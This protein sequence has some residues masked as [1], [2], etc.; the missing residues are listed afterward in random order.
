MNILKVIRT[1]FKIIIKVNFMFYEFYIK[2]IKNITNF[3]SVGEKIQN[4][5]TTVIAEATHSCPELRTTLS[6][7]PQRVP[8]ADLQPSEARRVTTSRGNPTTQAAETGNLP[9]SM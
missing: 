8:A 3:K 7:V 5:K 6:H 1:Y 4:R 2:I 9:F